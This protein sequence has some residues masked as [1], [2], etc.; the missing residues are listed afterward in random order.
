MVQVA[1]TKNY[2]FLRKDEL[3]LL[4]FGHRL[5]SLESVVQVAITKNDD[6]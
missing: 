1:I 3:A 2:D 4:Q 5:E 6:F